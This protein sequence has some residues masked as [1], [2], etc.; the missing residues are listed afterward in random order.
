MI[1][2]F[3]RRVA[4]VVIAA[5]VLQ[6]QIGGAQHVPI[7]DPVLNMQAWSLS[8]PAGWRAEGTMLPGSSCN[9]ST[10][11]VYRA[12]SAD[13]RTGAYF[14]P[15]ADWAW[16]AGTRA[17]N[18][19]LPWHEVVSAKD[20][21]TYQTRVEKAGFVSEQPAP[22]AGGGLPPG[23][24]ADTARYLVRYS[25]NGR[26]VDEL[27]TANVT[28]HQGTVMG[29]GEQ[30]GCAAFVTRWFAPHGRL[31]PMLPAFEA[32]KLTLNQEWMNEWTAAMVRR[33]QRLYQSQ[34][35]ALLAQGRLAGAQRMQAHQDFMASFEHGRDIRNDRFKA[36][37]YEKQR[38][39][40]NYVDYILDCQRAY[41]GNT[42]VSADNCP[43][44][45]TF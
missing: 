23:W 10:T 17:S 22:A 24:T 21:L 45:Q 35:D 2:Q 25:V 34:T 39:N 37:Q 15:R 7:N 1:K 38:T 31:E 30:H 27:L 12:T 41:R 13:G 36:G 28:C 19:C 3:T 32:M 14:L 8:V 29:V 4:P 43:N 5:F 40:D 11:P 44:R 26:L 42:R 9:A 18:D 33:T 16:G 20:F 6:G